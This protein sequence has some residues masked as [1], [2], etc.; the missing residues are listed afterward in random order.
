MPSYSYVFYAEKN[1]TLLI[2]V[3]FYLSLTRHILDYVTGR[4]HRNKLVFAGFT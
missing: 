2:D 1:T 4:F 3:F